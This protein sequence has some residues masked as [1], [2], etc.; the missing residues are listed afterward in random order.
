[1]PTQPNTAYDQRLIILK[2][3]SILI[4][5]Y[6]KFSIQPLTVPRYQLIAFNVFKKPVLF[7]PKQQT[8]KFDSIRTD[9]IPR[10][11]SFT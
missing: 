9:R 7:N 5:Q 1:M 8:I 2:L 10:F 4:V 6:T 11:Y 3:N